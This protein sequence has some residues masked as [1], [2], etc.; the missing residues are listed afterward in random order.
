VI[1]VSDGDAE[2][3]GDLGRSVRKEKQAGHK[4]EDVRIERV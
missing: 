1:E 2:E 3:L 4:I